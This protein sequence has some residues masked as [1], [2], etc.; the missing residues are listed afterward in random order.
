MNPPLC[1]K[2][3]SLSIMHLGTCIFIWCIV[4]LNSRV[5]WINVVL[6]CVRNVLKSYENVFLLISNWYLSAKLSLYE[7]MHSLNI[8]YCQIKSLRSFFPSFTHHITDFKS[9]LHVPVWKSVLYFYRIILVTNPENINAINHTNH[10]GDICDP[11][12]RERG[13]FSYLTRLR[14]RYKVFLY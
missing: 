8:H 9:Y 3:L 5:A 4:C 6:Y 14:L 12:H 1:H 2:E 13:T 11:T 10:D 7:L